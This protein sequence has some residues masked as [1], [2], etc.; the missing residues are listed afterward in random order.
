MAKCMNCGSEF[1]AKRADARFC[2]EKCRQIAHRKSVTDKLNQQSVTDIPVKYFTDTA[3][4]QHQ[5]DYKGRRETQALLDSWRHGE[6][7]AE[8]QT[9]AI[10]GEQYS[11]IKGIDKQEYLGYE[12]T[13]HVILDLPTCVPDSVR[14]RYTRGEP[15]YVRTINRL[16]S[17]SLAWLKAEGFWIPSWRHNAGENLVQTA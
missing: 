13:P 3:G 7:T 12:P 8:Q 9:L 15:A 2:S 10:L 17:S 16:V 4:V 14:N 6:G 1:E 5:V 11:T